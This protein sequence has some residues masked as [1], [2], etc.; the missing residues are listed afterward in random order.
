VT[1]IFDP[2]TA[3]VDHLMALPRS[4]FMLICTKIGFIRFIRFQTVVFRSLVAEERTD[5]RTG[6]RTDK[7]RTLCL[8][9]PVWPG[10][11]IKIDEIKI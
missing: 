2:L 11:P 8:C 9:L 7:L 3:T 5:A 10:G 1:L 4:P 6:E